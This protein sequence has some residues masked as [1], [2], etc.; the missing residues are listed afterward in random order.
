MASKHD[1]VKEGRQ[2]GAACGPKLI[3]KTLK[4]LC[5]ICD[6]TVATPSDRTLPCSTILPS[7][8]L[9]DPRSPRALNCFFTHCH[10]ALTKPWSYHSLPFASFG[11]N[12]AV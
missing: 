5:G 11:S 8:L 3:E 10:F 6:E 12:F 7:T 2:A 1:W 9:K 4:A